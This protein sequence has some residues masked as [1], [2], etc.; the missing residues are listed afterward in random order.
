MQYLIYGMQ[1]C[2]W[3]ARAKNF[4]AS[5]RITFKY[6]DI[7][8][9]ADA[10]GYIVDLEGHKTVPQVYVEDAM[11]VRTHIGGHDDLVEHLKKITH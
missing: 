4:L 6:I 8:N 2:V 10:R 1:G 9:D 5:K 3:C 11:G 7:L